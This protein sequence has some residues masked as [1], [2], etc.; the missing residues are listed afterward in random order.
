MLRGV[1]PADGEAQH[2]MFVGFTAPLL[3]FFV[4]FPEGT[5]SEVAKLA[6]EDL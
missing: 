2:D 5:P 4:T 3:I 1:Y 6:I